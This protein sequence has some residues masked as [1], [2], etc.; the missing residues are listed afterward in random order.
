MVQF[1]QPIREKATDLQ[2]NTTL[3]NNI[4]AEGAEKARASAKATIQLVRA[5]VLG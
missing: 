3:L 2:N 1:I 5:A 4:I